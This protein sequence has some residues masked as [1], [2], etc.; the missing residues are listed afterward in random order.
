[1]QAELDAI[2]CVE[3]N[4][5]KRLDRIFA[6]AGALYG[7]NYRKFFEELDASNAETIQE[8]DLRISP[9]SLSCREHDG[10]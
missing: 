4:V 1:M 7:G 8:K 2:S 9:E 6:R 10:E 5:E 3:P